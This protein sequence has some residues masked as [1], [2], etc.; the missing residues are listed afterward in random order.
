MKN[1]IRRRCNQAFSSDSPDPVF[2][3]E[4]EEESYGLTR[5]PSSTVPLTLMKRLIIDPL[6]GGALPSELSFLLSF[7]PSIPPSLPPLSLSL[8]NAALVGHSSYYT[9]HNV[10]GCLGLCNS[11]SGDNNLPSVQL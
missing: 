1:E 3:D 6:G 2:E 11:Y 4:V 8:Q 10:P 9:W 5:Q 7:P